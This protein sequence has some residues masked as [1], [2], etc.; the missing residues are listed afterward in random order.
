MVALTALQMETIERLFAA[1]FRP[2]AIAPYE[3][4]GCVHRGECGGLLG[5]GGNGGLRLLAPATVL[6]DG[7]LSVRLKREHGEVFVWKEK[8]VQATEDRLKELERF[9]SELVRILEL[10]GRE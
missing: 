6:V 1:G 9:R 7:N 8:E 10:A 2:I 3:R 5:P 4:V